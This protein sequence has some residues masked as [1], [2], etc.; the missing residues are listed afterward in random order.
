[1]KPKARILVVEDDK[2]IAMEIKDRLENF[3]YEVPAI[4]FTG[5][6]AISA[7]GELLPNLVLMDIHLKGS[8]DGIE[9]ADRIHSLLDIPVIYLTAYADESTL[10]R[11]KITEPY[12][13]IVKP[14]E[15]RELHSTIEI[16]LYK[17][18]I[19]RKLK[20]SEENYRAIVETFDGF[21]YVNTPENTVKFMNKKMI[22][23]VGY[24]ATGEVCYKA[25]YSQ[26]TVCPWCANGPVFKGNTVKFERHSNS[27]KH[28][29]YEVSTPI[30]HPDGFIYKQS[31]IQDITERKTSEAKLVWDES[32][33][34]Q[35]TN[36]SPLGFYAVDENNGEI[37]Y[38]NHRY[39]EL[40]KLEKEAERKMFAGKL[41]DNDLKDMQSMYVKNLTHFK[42]SY[43]QFQNI[44]NRTR[45]EDEILLTD[46]RTIKRFTTQLRDKNDR[47]L[48]RL[49]IYEDIT[50][51]ILY[52][53]LLKSEEQ[54]RSLI[55][56]ASDAIAVTD[57]EDNL[58][59][60]NT[61]LAQMLNYS[62]EELLQMNF[63]DLVDSQDIEK[64][65]LV[66]SGLYEGKSTIS[67]KKLRTKNGS[68]V[69][70]E[71]NAK[72]FT[73]D[74]VHAIIRDVTERKKQE[75][76]LKKA[77]LD[78]IYEKLFTKLH[79]FRHGENSAMNLNRLS[80][81]TKNLETIWRNKSDR[82]DE[83]IDQSGINNE[84]TLRQAAFDRLANTITEYRDIV[85]PQIKQ[86]A[87]LLGVIETEF[88][89]ILLQNEFYISSK[90]IISASD[91]LK[92]LFDEILNI[93][94]E[95]NYEVDLAVKVREVTECIKL[96]KNSI[97]NS[98][99]LLETNFS[100]E[101]V[102]LS[103][104]LLQKYQKSASIIKFHLEYSSDDLKAII[105]PI[106]YQ[107]VLAVLIENAVDSLLR[108]PDRTDK[109]LRVSISRL[110][111]LI[112]IEVENNG[113]KIDELLKNLIFTE[114]FTTK[115]DGRGFGLSFAK[116][117]IEK[118]GGKLYLDNKFDQGARFIIELLVN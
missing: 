75:D 36:S 2:I 54:Y 35:M 61:K 50:E 11:A 81:Y 94:K 76:E 109:L 69:H 49:F 80:L 59:L 77:I 95:G 21:I 14:L 27:D 99:K 85:A 37:L 51:R 91:N 82:I 4:V 55:E 13:Y 100:S 68:I 12:G 78:E 16:T 110:D 103:K 87:Y 79:A 71:I 45:F 41:K 40:W 105:N 20:E 116:K 44:D 18:Q 22:D 102:K 58:I 42:D 66:L 65:V 39:C 25:L 9:V 38:H 101:I 53:S 84:V 33:L 90:D 113:E 46:G 29:Y 92:Q 1:L 114:N 30:N 47:Y 26:E 86:I 3:G 19:E 57:I 31:M 28:W 48:G 112:R 60:I 96:I 24:D 106:D 98:S 6:Q 67:N 43:L 7:A 10:Q 17:H 83:N 64:R 63:K 8:M 117:S 93:I 107:E 97:R 52:E 23:Y 73:K 108:E 74:R 62:K 72:M 56:Q 89:K 34:R 88:D 5:E 115:G 32:L 118:Y 104:A 15:E 70:V 111:N